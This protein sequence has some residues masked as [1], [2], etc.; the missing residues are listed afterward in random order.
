MLYMMDTRKEDEDTLAVRCLL[1]A[2]HSVCCLLCT[3][4]AV[5][6]ALCVLVARIV[7]TDARTA[8]RTHV[9]TRNHFE[10]SSEIA[11]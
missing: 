5:C 3:L 8:S 11:M 4:S 1:S 2:L 6:S 9:H 10:K 7:C